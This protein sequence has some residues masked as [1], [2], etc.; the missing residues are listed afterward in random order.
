MKLSHNNPCFTAFSEVSLQE[1]ESEGSLI[2]IAR[3][4]RAVG[5]N[6]E[7]VFFAS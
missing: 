5:L 1:K 7:T 3:E 2:A 4:T 6:D